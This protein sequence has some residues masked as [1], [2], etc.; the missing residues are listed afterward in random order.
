MKLY[1]K[2]SDKVGS[3]H[4]GINKKNELATINCSDSCRT[5][6]GIGFQQM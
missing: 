2:H 1:Q 3:G 4:N 6:A 5:K